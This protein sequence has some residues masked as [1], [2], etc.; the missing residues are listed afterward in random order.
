MDPLRTTTGE[1]GFSLIELIVVMAMLS[2]ALGSILTVVERTTRLSN[3]DR[4]RSESIRSAQVE[5]DGV[6]REA[7]QAFRVNASTASKLDISLH[8]AG[9]T[10]RVIFDCSV[11]HPTLNTPT[12]PTRRC[13]RQEMLPDGTLTAARVVVD[14][15]RTTNVFAYTPATGATEHVEVNVE[16][17][18]SGERRGP[19]FKHLIRL[20]DGFGVRNRGL[21]P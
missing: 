3:D 2:V 16:V 5:L 20:H 1:A 21:V 11:M 19:G 18:A 10:R 12:T 13:T 8:R 9:V 7:R 15:I 14:R 17:P 6:I 4:E